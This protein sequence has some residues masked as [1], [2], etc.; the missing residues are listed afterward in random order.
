MEFVFQVSFFLHVSIFF[1]PFSLFRV[2]QVVVVV[3]LL[4]LFFF[5]LSFS[6]KKWFKRHSMKQWEFVFVTPALN[7]GIPFSFRFYDW[8]IITIITNNTKWLHT[9]IPILCVYVCLSCRTSNTHYFVVCC[10][11]SLYL[12]CWWLIFYSNWALS[13]GMTLVTME[14]D[15]WNGHQS[16]ENCYDNSR[17]SIINIEW[18]D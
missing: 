16:D 12:L 4:Y 7:G 17:R 10:F 18:A 9:A 1:H 15:T 13:N 14:R 8:W 3:L 2:A 5:S 6:T 11:L